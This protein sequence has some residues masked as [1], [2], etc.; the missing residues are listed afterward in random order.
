MCAA[1]E[2]TAGVTDIPVRS[3]LTATDLRAF[4]ASA[5][6]AA[7]ESRELSKREKL[8]TRENEKALLFETQDKERKD[9]TIHKSYVAK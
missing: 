6:G 4:L 9:A 2:A 1:I 3:T 7:A 8:V 5:D